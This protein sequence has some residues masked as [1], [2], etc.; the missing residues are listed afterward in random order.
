MFKT[1]S[2]IQIILDIP[3]LFGICN[4]ELNSIRIFNPKKINALFIVLDFKSNFYV[5][6]DYK[7]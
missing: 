4:P 1:H 6:Q 3:L 2:L 7:S 5:I